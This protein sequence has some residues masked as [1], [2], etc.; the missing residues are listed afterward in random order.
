MSQHNKLNALS[1]LAYIHA[2]VKYIHLLLC[3]HAYHNILT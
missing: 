2:Y 1:S 3:C